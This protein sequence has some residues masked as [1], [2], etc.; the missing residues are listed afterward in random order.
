MNCNFKEGNGNPLKTEPIFFLV[1]KVFKLKNNIY[2][3]LSFEENYSF[4]DLSL[5]S[6]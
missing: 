4:L 6:F 3:V 2:K 1:E 5:I